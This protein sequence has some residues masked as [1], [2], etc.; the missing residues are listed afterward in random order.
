[1]KVKL[2]MFTDF[3]L[4]LWFKSC[5]SEICCQFFFFGRTCCFQLQGWSVLGG[6]MVTL[7]RQCFFLK[8]VIQGDQKVSVHMMTTILKVTSNVQSV[9]C[10]SPDIYRHAECIP[11]WPTLNQLCGDCSNTLSFLYCNYQVHRDFLIILYNNALNLCVYIVYQPCHFM[12]IFAS[13]NSSCIFI[14]IGDCCRPPD[15][16]SVVLGDNLVSYSEIANCSSQTITVKAR[17]V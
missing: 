9:P 1:M 2:H 15:I 4:S 14:F 7:T 5:R 3:R 12:G 11:W 17:R 6:R 13:I 16:F 10:Q 8:C